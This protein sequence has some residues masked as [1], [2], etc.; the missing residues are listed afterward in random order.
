MK[1]DRD[2]LKTRSVRQPKH[3]VCRAFPS[4]TVVL[5][6]E[7]GTYHGLNPTGGRMLEELNKADSVGAAAAKL[8]A[9]F[10][11]STEVVEHDVYEFCTGL[12]D[13]GLLEVEPAA[14]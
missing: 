9:E 11:Q 7:T 3:V 12:I 14:G 1:F 10:G 13:R 2:Q 8:A 4:E 5:N 6:L